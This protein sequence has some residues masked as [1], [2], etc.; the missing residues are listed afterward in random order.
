MLELWWIRHGQSQWNVENR[1]QGHS[2][3]P[4]S[5]EG[6][7]QALRLRRALSEVHFDA[8]YSSDLCR[9]V[10]T[11]ELALPALAPRRDGRLREVHF[12]EFEGLTRADMSPEQLERL[13]VWFQDPYAGRVLGGESLT[14]VGERILAWQREL[15]ESGRIAVF[16]HG[17]VIRCHLWAASGESNPWKVQ[18]DN[19]STTCVVHGPKGADVRWVN[20]TSYVSTK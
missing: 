12:G 16:T 1:W 5:D 2:D 19:C 18:I 9:A 20:D 6:E 8:V 17:G 14:E 15:P 10:R 7:Q 4:L 11:A 13:K 3:I